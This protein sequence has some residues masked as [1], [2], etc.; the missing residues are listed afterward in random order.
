M[1]HIILCTSFIISPYFSFIQFT[2]YRLNP[3]RPDR[4]LYIPRHR[5]A[6]SKNVEL[7]Q[8]KTK[9]DSMSDGSHDLP[10]NSQ[11][12][13]RPFQVVDC[14]IDPVAANVCIDSV[15][16][17]GEEKRLGLPSTSESFEN[18]VEVRR[19][20]GKQESGF[21]KEEPGLNDCISTA[22]NDAG[23]LVGSVSECIY[24]D[25]RGNG[26]SYLKATETD[27]F[28]DSVES[29]PKTECRSSHSVE[30]QENDPPLTEGSS[31]RVLNCHEYRVNCSIPQS[32]AQDFTETEA[33]IIDN[34]KGVENG[35]VSKEQTD[36]K[37]L[38][39]LVDGS[40]KCKAFKSYRKIKIH[41]K[42]SKSNRTS[43]KTEK[44]DA[45]A[46]ND[47]MNDKDDCAEDD[48]W[49]DKWDE[50]GNCISKE[51]KNEVFKVFI[52]L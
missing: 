14:D 52:C 16:S 23:T 20:I 31:S 26:L 9:C 30:I 24:N 34:A 4:E 11:R 33:S 46:M 22:F 48:D 28:R 43:E 36:I 47:S 42:E 38:T 18:S 49:F 10:P 50:T 21:E 13:K 44:V 17:G 29:L 2:F 41:K 5:K 15:V 6:T 40:E 25:C 27:S 45:N 8:E 12:E 51:A 32:G 35:N 3:K 1:L 19:E 37:D 7:N 39:S